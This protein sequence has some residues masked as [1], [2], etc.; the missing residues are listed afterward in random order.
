M[1][2]IGIDV[3]K[4]TLDVAVHGHGKTHQ[5]KNTPAGIKR[6][7]AWLATHSD[8]RALMEA[9][10]GY[11]E[12]ALEACAQAGLWV[13]R[14]NPRQARD[15]AKATGQLAKTDTLDARVLAEMI[16]VL[17]PRLRRHVPA[18]AWQAELKAW[19]VRRRQVID[20]LQRSHQQSLTAPNAV[21]VAMRNSL[22]ALR[23]ELKTIDAHMKSI[24]QLHATPALQSAKGLGAVFQ[25][26]ALA[27][28]PELGQLSRQQIAKLV[29]VAP[30]NRDSG[31]LQ[32]KRMIYGGRAAMRIA[33]YMATLSAVRWEP[34]LRDHYQQLRSRG[35]VAKVALVAC[36]RKLLGIVN[37]RRRD[38]LRREGLLAV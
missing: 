28:L 11:E 24:T 27:M 7:V 9:T 2:A 1:Q 22:A 6:L 29:G 13:V 19:L 4:A 38:E 5:F 30:L 32:G 35:K 14:V 16:A 10:G 17:H 36:M 26:T 23:K 12:P 8:P 31:Q 18:P 25:T 34:A 15:F 21:R 20:T 37:A 33:L 3:S